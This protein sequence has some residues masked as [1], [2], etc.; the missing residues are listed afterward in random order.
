MTL[1]ER[2]IVSAYTGVL[3]CD[4]DTFHGWLENLMGRPLLSHELALN[5]VLYEAIKE[6]VKPRFME[7]CGDD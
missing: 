4:W 2:L 1:E 6:K 7:L 5:D 3:M